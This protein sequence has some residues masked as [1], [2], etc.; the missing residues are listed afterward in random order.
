MN[1]FD[2]PDRSPGYSTIFGQSHR[3]FK[4]THITKNYIF[5]F[6]LLSHLSS[7]LRPS[8]ILK[9]DGV[10]DP[11]LLLLLL[12]FIA[13]IDDLFGSYQPY[14]TG[15]DLGYA[16]PNL[17][18]KLVSQRSFYYQSVRFSFDLIG[19]PTLTDGHRNG[20]F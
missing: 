6:Y 19:Q 20:L 2:T 3:L 15:I 4:I 8:Q 16:L 10:I 18:E 14:T 11:A 1:R 13:L 5:L 17:P 7:F 9:P 12:C